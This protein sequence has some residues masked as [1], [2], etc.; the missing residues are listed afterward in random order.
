MIETVPASFLAHL[1]DRQRMLLHQTCKFQ[2]E[3]V[4][5]ASNPNPLKAAAIL[6]HA[7]SYVRSADGLFFGLRMWAADVA[8][9]LDIN[10]RLPAGGANDHNN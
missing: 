5:L 10:W 1:T 7:R 6:R 4:N 3:R 9:A 2:E 8:Y